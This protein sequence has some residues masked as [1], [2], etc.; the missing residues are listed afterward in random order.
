MQAGERIGGRYRLDARLGRGGM[1]EVWSGFD[2]QLGRA[3]AVK[4]LLDSDTGAEPLERFRR[5]ASIGARFRHPGITVVHDVGQHEHRLFIVMEL[6]EGA[7][8]AEVLSRSPGGLPVARAISL[9]LQAA[10]ALA[11]AHAGRVVHRDLKPGNLFL[12]SDGRLKICDFGIARAADLTSGVTVTGRPFGTPAYMAP[13]Q[14]RGEHVDAKCDLYAF[15]CV[16]HELLTGAPPFTAGEGAWGLMRR[17]IDEAAPD[18]RSVRADVPV[19]VADLVASLLAK[20]PTDRPDATATVR[21][22]RSL[23]EG[24]PGL[25]SALTETV[26]PPS[27]NPELGED[28]ATTPLAPGARPDGPGA[29][30]GRR[31]SRRALLVAGAG[32]LAAVSVPVAVELASR[33]GG[34]GSAAPPT[35]SRGTSAPPVDLA[36]GNTVV[37]VAFSPD[38]AVLAA[39]VPAGSTVTLWNVA[40]RRRLAPLSGHMALPNGVRFSPDGKTLAAVD[41]SG[42]VTLWAAGTHAYLATIGNAGEVSTA[43]FA[44]DSETLA[45]GGRD[46]TV[47]LWDRATSSRTL[48]LSAPAAAGPPA[49]VNALS[50]N[51]SGAA[52]AAGR[53]DHVVRVW[54]LPDTRPAA[55]LVGHTDVVTTV[56]F[57]TADPVSLASGS[58]DHTIRLWTVLTT[59]G[60]TVRAQRVLTGHTGIVRSVAYSPDG[61]TLAS[62]GD[63]HTVRLWDCRA[64]SSRTTPVTVLTGRTGH[65]GP[66]NAVA[67]SH[68]GKTLATGSSDGTVKLWP[69]A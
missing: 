65:T 26:P 29:A 43:A 44:P 11:A 10:E 16:L 57:S 67:F 51:V 20:D 64:N 32:A 42:T 37:S 52:L 58:A 34:K 39:A 3:V 49:G 40:T 8:L 54:L 9:G 50:Y 66:V 35:S 7:D 18:L 33:H 14:W 4:L 28:T 38:D 53:D 31:L 55:H 27:P 59:S 36:A 6:L 22:L 56:A 46:G 13:E 69:V 45:C 62:G 15:G 48:A 17:H 2:L 25:H 63:D 24:V 30:Q 47:S 19:E 61:L 5:E 21:V 1:G 41:G 12:Q 68:D 23:Q 60:G